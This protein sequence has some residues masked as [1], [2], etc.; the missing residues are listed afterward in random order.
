LENGVHTLIEKPISDNIG[1]AEE[2][3]SISKENNCILLVG[4]IERYN[5]VISKIKKEIEN[6]TFG[7]IYSFSSKRLGMYTPKYKDNVLFDLSVHDIDVMRYLS[8]SE[9]HSVFAVCENN[10]HDN[11]D[12]YAIILN[13]NNGIF[14]IIEVSWLATYGI[15]RM[16]ITCQNNM[17]EIDYSDQSYKKS[18]RYMN[19]KDN[20]VSKT[21]KTSMRKIEPLKL[22]IEDFIDSILHKKEPLVGGDDGLMNLKIATAAIESNNLGKKVYIK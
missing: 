10:I 21:T 3:I 1:N 9:V 7:H 17:V 12:N 8:E 22:E 16:E 5:P 20:I 15:R 4:H 6:N 11:I 18:N 13:F 19:E 2:L 14:G